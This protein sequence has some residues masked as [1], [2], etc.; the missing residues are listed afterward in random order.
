VRKL[1]IIA[2]IGGLI[3]AGAVALAGG[4]DA[5]ITAPTANAVL[6]GN[7]TL[8]DSPGASITTACALFNTART[9]INLIN[10][11]NTTVFTQNVGSSTFGGN[12]TLPL[13]TSIDTHSYANGNY[14]VQ[15]IEQSYNGGFAGVGCSHPSTTS[16]VAVRID[17]IVALAYSGATH[18]AQGTSVTVSATL[19]DPNLATSVLPGRVV[20]FSLSTGGS[21][22]AT[23]DSNGLATATL[24][25]SGPP[26]AAT[27]TTS[28]AATS[29]YDAN[30]IQTA[31]TVDKDA[32]SVAVNPPAGSVHGQSTSFTATVSQAQ[33]TVAD[34]PTGTVQFFVDGNALGGTVPV[35]AGSA[36]SPSTSTLST[37]THVVTAHYSGDT[38]LLASDSAGVNAVVSKAST[39]TTISAN[40]P[41]SVHGQAITFTANVS[42]TGLGAGTPTGAVQFDVDGQPFGTA[43][44]LTG[45]SASLTISSLS[46][47]QHNVTATYDGDANFAISTSTAVQEQVGKAGTTSVISSSDQTSVFGESI[48]FSVD[49]SANSPGAGTPTGTATFAVD[50]TQVGSP[51][52]LVDGA[53]Q[54]DVVS[55]LTPG[56]HT[57]TVSYSGD[58]DF[59][60]ST[61]QLTQTVNQDATKT[62]ISSSANPSVFGQPVTFHAAVSS[63]AP[64]SGVPTGSVQFYINGSPV[65]S[66]VSL[67]N[68]AADSA[69]IAD[70]EPGTYTVTAVYS[71]DDDY[72]TSTS[73]DL[74]QTVN[75]AA[76][77]TSISS[78]ANPSVFGQPVTFT[79]AVSVT[80][81]GAGNPTGTITFTDGGNVLGVVPVGPQTGE[82]ASLTTSALV[83]APHAIVATYSGDNEFLTSN[84]SLTQTVNRAQ[85]STLVTSSDNPAASGEP[86]TFTATITPVA[87][88]A[89][90]PSGTVVFTVN[91]APL[92]SPATVVN[93]VA[94][95]TTFASLSP[96]KYTISAT[97]SG[98]GNFVGSSAVL[99]EGT[100]QNVSKANT[101]TS[102][103]TSGTPANYASTVTFTATVAR[104]SLI[105]S[106][107]PSGL[108]QFF[109]GTQLLGSAQLAPVGTT[110]SKATFAYS[111]LATGSHTIT[112]QYVG[113]Y[114]FNGSS[115]TVAQSINSMP[116]QIGLVSS[117]NPTFYEQPTVFTAVVTGPTG[118]PTG[119]VTFKDGSTVLGTANLALVQGADQAS[120]LVSSLHAGTHTITATYNGGGPY[121]GSSATL[122]QTVV[123]AT[124]QLVANPIITDQ[125][126]LNRDGA[127]LHLTIGEASATLTANGHP[128]VGQTIVFTTHGLENPS[129]PVCTAVTD[130]NGFAHCDTTVNNGDNN[131]ATIISANGYLAT[132]AGTSD[133]SG[134]SSHGPLDQ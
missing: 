72:V 106:G 54:S 42:V 119:T 81:A 122:T 92:G 53:A 75:K 7:A 26:G 103:T 6:R 35:V 121:A 127:R 108:V 24:P 67:I 98:D 14:T 62:V 124:S 46:T 9:T 61:D 40:P 117:V 80:G 15:G 118:T 89:G 84:S 12:Q 25:V 102:V 64:G 70:L 48:T 23:T 90:V 74:A 91:G 58:D 77:A 44:P 57:V 73:P 131:L 107:K 3:A 100:G 38:N 69:P 34:A 132:Y 82:M 45:T 27:L 114:N 32:S 39:A 22:S 133:F 56:A 55:L 113:N 93:G 4:A 68:G 20:S 36:T 78:N 1:T 50:G 86:I 79:A 125:A 63:V 41:A 49:I 116:T 60:G 94:T 128:L 71:G 18:G 28:F 29:F 104:S 2:T 87:P 52:T 30:S 105:G 5:A 134:A 95:S 13:T 120:L 130:S 43:V 65:G 17:N 88:G 109:D 19:T 96:G 111:S 10:S 101:T 8:T 33:G 129:I 66:S 11:S 85:S 99:D 76:T 110:S 115:A 47:A 59:N 126:A 16:N 31:F 123:K 37:A 83:V 97:Y 21:A 112:A 51:V